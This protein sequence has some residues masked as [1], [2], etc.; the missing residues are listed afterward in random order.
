VNGIRMV[1]VAVILLGVLR[2]WAQGES[3]PHAQDVPGAST[4]GASLVQEAL[5]LEQQGRYPEAQARWEEVVKAEPGNGQA[6]A[7][8][9]F[10]QA[11]QGHYTDAIAS[12]RKAKAINPGIAQLN[13]NLGLALFK[14]GKFQ[15]AGTLF[16]EELRK[17]PNDARL[18][19][20]VAMSHYGA[21]EYWGGNPLF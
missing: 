11:R 10:L 7:Q 4:S 5:R 14:S 3:S 16:E 15:E 12:Y 19:T 2:G 9:G 21:H 6:F 18:T 17:H 8:L 13:L 20:L 1:C